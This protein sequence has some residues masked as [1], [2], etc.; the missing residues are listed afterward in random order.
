MRGPQAEQQPRRH[1]LLAHERSSTTR[2]SEVIVQLV[3]GDQHDDDLGVLVCYGTGGAKT[4]QAWH[5][6]VHEHDVGKHLR[7]ALQRGLA[8]VRGVDQHESVRGIDDVTR[9]VAKRLLIVDNKHA[10]PLRGSRPTTITGR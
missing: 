4:P 3:G 6:N 7:N 10:H 9:R 5:P 8:R 1:L 2:V